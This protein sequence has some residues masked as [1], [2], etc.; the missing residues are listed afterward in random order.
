MKTKTIKNSTKK[1]KSS[2]LKFSIKRKMALR[3]QVPFNISKI[4]QVVT[5]SL[6]LLLPAILSF[7]GNLCESIPPNSRLQLR[8]VFAKDVR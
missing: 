5:N 1:K 2:C 7:L 4:L 3:K 8:P 6:A